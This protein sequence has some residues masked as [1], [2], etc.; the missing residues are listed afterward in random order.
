M[1]KKILIT[2]INGFLGQNLANFFNKKNLCVFGIDCVSLNND[3]KTTDFI[4][5]PVDLKALTSFNIKFDLIIHCAGGSTVGASI[6]DPE[7]EYNKTVNSTIEVLEYIKN[8]NK[9]AK[10]I[11]PSSAAVYGNAYNIPICEDKELNP[12]SPYG[13]HKK[14]AED[15]CRKFHNDFGISV[16]IIRFFSLY[17]SGLK[18]QLLWDACNKFQNEEKI[19]FFGTGKESRDWLHID[20]AV[21]LIYKIYE[22]NE[23][24]NIYNGGTGKNLPTRSILKLLSSNFDKD[25]KFT[26]NN[27]IR[28]GDPLYLCAD[29]SKVKTICWHPQKEIEEGIKE[30]V[31]WFKEKN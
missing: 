14:I 21:N 15:I 8:H 3:L 27:L 19:E 25:I 4:E 30:Y 24:F 17:G 2:G 12:L 18:K 1:T 23:S 10:L 20:D 16:S 9:N 26:F 11:Y 6:K 7:G 13:Q 29:T 28:E 31:L 5:A 22:V